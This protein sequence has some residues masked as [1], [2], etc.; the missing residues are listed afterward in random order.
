MTWPPP[1]GIDI[2]RY[3]RD[4][5]K[6]ILLRSGLDKPILNQNPKSRRFWT[7]LGVARPGLLWRGRPSG[8][9][10][11]SWDR[12]KVGLCQATI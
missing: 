4:L 6:Y 2:A 8:S 10:W 7:P 1:G 9:K 3:S 12:A 5:D 11:T